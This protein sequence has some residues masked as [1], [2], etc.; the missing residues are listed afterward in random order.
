M[1]REDSRMGKFEDIWREQCEATHGNRKRFSDEATLDYLVGEKLLH[2]VSAARDNPAFATLL[3]AFVGE[4]RQ[5]FP[6]ENMASYITR[7]E[8]R[9]TKTATSLPSRIRILGRA[10]SMT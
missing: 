2:Y 6:R 9:L 8:Q 3:P 5:M 4:V 1:V 7:L 10:P